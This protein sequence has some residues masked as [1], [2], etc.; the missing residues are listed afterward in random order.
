LR[1][2]GS[3][4]G[5]VTKTTIANCGLIYYDIFNARMH[6]RKRHTKKER[7]ILMKKFII[8]AVFVLAAASGVKAAGMEVG[9]MEVGFG[10]GL[11]IP[12]SSEYKD[13]NTGC[14]SS[15]MLDLYGQYQIHE[16]LA[17]GLDMG[18]DFGHKSKVAGAPDDLKLKI[19]QI[20]PFVKFEQPFD[21]S[22]KKA[23][24]FAKLGVGYYNLKSTEYTMLGVTTPSSNVGKLGFNLGIG[25]TM[26]VAPQFAVGLDVTYHYVTKSDMVT[27]AAGER[28]V[29]TQLTPA[30]HG[31]YRF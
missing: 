10:P 12:M 18:Y 9:K 6:R 11:A 13:S 20:T 14:K 28:Q 15:F 27:N 2:E 3:D 25:A 22:G 17:L 24:Y 5:F 8:A 23:T 31:I 1:E 16:M 4:G 26:E 7:E 29:L 21:L 19:L 30:I